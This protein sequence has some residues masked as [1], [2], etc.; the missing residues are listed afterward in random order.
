MRDAVLALDVGGTRIKAL[1]QDEHGERLDEFIIDTPVR[2]DPLATIAAIVDLAVERSQSEPHD[3]NPVAIGLAIPGLVDEERGIAIH[4]EN[5]GWRD[6]DLA[7]RFRDRTELPVI[8]SQDVR[9]GARAELHS[10]SARGASSMLF[11]PIGTGVGAALV[12]DG[13]VRTGPH[14]R[15][16]EIGHIPV[17]S[18]TQPCLCGKIGCLESIASATAIR[19]RYNA[20]ANASAGGAGDVIARAAQGDPDAAAVWDEAVDALAASLSAA[21]LILDLDRVVI[22]G[23]LSLAGETLL[24]PLRSRLALH[25]SADTAVVGALHR[26]LAGAVGAGVRAWAAVR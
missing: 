20:R 16:G 9:A 26:D 2:A 18:S 12:L 1:W 22:G 10:G 21:D 24:E 25:G 6:I 4:S 3:V 17:G 11:V 19:T 15:A 14:N 13:V 23:G 5:L 7:A 8:I